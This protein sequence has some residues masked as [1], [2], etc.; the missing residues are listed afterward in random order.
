MTRVSSNSNVNSK[1]SVKKAA[2]DA[3]AAAKPSAAQT[4]SG[5]QQAAASKAEDDK[6]KDD[7]KDAWQE[8]VAFTA[9]QDS[10]IKELKAANKSWK[11]IA[12][13][14]DLDHKYLTQ[15]KN[16]FKEIKDTPAETSQSWVENKPKPIV[17]FAS[18]PLPTTAEIGTQTDDFLARDS[19]RHHDSS[20]RRDSVLYR[21]V[22]RKRSSSSHHYGHVLS[23][24]RRESRS[25]HHATA[26]VSGRRFAPAEVSF[27]IW[28]LVETGPLT[29]CFQMA[30][31]SEVVK[32]DE[33]FLF[34][35]LCES[36]FGRTSRR[37]HP[38][39]L[40]EVLKIQ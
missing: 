11:E 24:S 14:I 3:G 38:E 28:D 39:D 32:E 40:R 20:P 15:L 31:I 13:A 29:E 12:T 21:D 18:N 27:M 37:I 35:R 25:R 6:P 16:R 8:N 22:S 1:A 26:A 10:K 19:S 7:K 23:D 17:S 30:L 34:L 4:N 9:D 5:A 2:T 36:F 33:K